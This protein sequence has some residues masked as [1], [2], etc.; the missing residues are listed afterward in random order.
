MGV[1]GV[2]AGWWV[3]L[4]L[5]ARA[6]CREWSGR[7]RGGDGAA[8]LGGVPAGEGGVDE[9]VEPFPVAGQGVDHDLRVRGTDGLRVIDA[10]VFPTMPSGN[11]AAPTMALARMIGERIA[12]EAGSGVRSARI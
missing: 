2:D 5:T 4:H 9:L 3:T 10:S 6:W 12:R 11:N 7:Q 1:S 8:E